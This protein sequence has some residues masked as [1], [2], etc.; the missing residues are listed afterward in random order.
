VTTATRPDRSNR[1]IFAALRSGFRCATIGS[2]GRRA[3]P[4]ENTR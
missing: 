2:A 4:V 3:K 1:L